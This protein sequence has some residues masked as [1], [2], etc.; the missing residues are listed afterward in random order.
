MTYAVNTHRD[1]ARNIVFGA[2]MAPMDKINLYPDDTILYNLEQVPGALLSG[3]PSEKLR[4]LST[5]FPDMGL[6]PA[7]FRVLERN[8]QQ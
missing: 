2:S 7:Q 8:K 3:Q 1:D 4:Y 5:K 6:Q